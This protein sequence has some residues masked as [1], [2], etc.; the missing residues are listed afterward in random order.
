MF[1]PFY[2]KKNNTIMVSS[3]RCGSSF[4]AE[5]C[6]QVPH[7]HSFNDKECLFPR[8]RK[9]N[10]WTSFS[11]MNE[12][13]C[14]A[15]V[16]LLY[17]HPVARYISA[18]PFVV[19][20][21]SAFYDHDAT[22]NLGNENVAL[23]DYQQFN[24]FLVNLSSLDMIPS[25]VFGESHLQPQLPV[26]AMMY[27]LLDTADVKLLHLNNYSQYIEDNYSIDIP[28]DREGVPYSFRGKGVD[29]DQLLD[30]G[31]N[32]LKFLKQ[33]SNMFGQLFDSWIAPDVEL[34][35]FL[36][37]SPTQDQVANKLADLI[38]RPG[39]LLRCAQVFDYFTD[40]AV[41][42]STK[43][44]QIVSAIN[45]ARFRLGKD[46]INQIYTAQRILRNR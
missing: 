2:D 44:P 32:L 15:Q 27:C 45:H 36:Q 5:I 24:E 6:E 28:Q 33:E 40:P 39:Y 42:E 13:Y 46:S 8:L 21:G 34:F 9:A 12:P 18:L 10:E 30:S 25:F 37:T 20:L 17:R 16:V 4:T 31:K 35:E 11:T 7:M 26:L 23:A 1:Q 19:G 43:Y 29:S 41:L 3:L 14:D 38:T 22:V